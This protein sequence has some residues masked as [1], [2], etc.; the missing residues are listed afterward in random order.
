LQG[1]DYIDV[2]ASSTKEYKLQFFAYKEG[3]NSADIVFRNEQTMEFVT[4]ETT[5]RAGPPGVMDTVH[6]T[7]VV[8]QP[9][10]HTITLDNPLPIPVTFA[11]AC[12]NL[13]GSRSTCTEVHAP[14]SF[15][16]PAKSEATEFTFDFLPVR[17]RESAARL[18]L[19]SA[20]LG[21]FQYDLTLTGT[22]APPL[23]TERLRASL[24]EACV[25][26]YKFT[27]FFPQRGEYTITIDS[28]EFSAPA[29]VATAAAMK[30]GTEASFDLTYE[31]TRLGDCRAT[32]TIS[33]ALGGEYVC[34]LF[35][36]CAAPKPSGPHTVRTGER[37]KLPFKNVFGS[38]ETFTYSCDGTAFS[39]K[40]TE[41]F[42]A[43]ETKEIVV[44]Y[45]APRD[46]TV[47]TA[48][49]VVAC[50]A[51]ANAGLEWIFY[52]KGVPA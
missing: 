47:R 17:A 41:T 39:I 22:P 31:P 42:R 2:P 21:V 6:L 36:Q 11:I 48:R 4:Y 14:Q 1:L 20:E 24:G 30:T 5:F 27:N 10:S 51:G 3:V 46:D 34:P 23:P 25:R 44:K 38:N 9:V 43:K 52:L 29:T 12:T 45:D 26:R 33:S 35:G 7:S 50:M 32:M 13:D 8:R 18:A 37:L 28:D 15:R 49:L 19:S 40:P 16:V